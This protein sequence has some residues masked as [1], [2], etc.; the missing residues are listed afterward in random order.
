[1]IGALADAGVG[2]QY[3]SADIGS[4]P[5]R[6]RLIGEVRGTFDALNLLVN[7]A[8]IAPRV[9]AD[10]LDVTEDSFEELIR[11][12]LQGPC[13]LTQAVVGM[14]IEQ[15]EANLQ[16]AACVINVTSISAVVASVN[17]G[18]YCISKAGLSMASKLWDVRLAEYGIHT[19]VRSSTRHHSDRHDLW[20]A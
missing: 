1:V 18:V 3:F 4:Q 5:D 13:F 10:I 12:N 7:K 20:C 11:I 2:E 17:R 14:M 6:E 9:R 19:C 16:I 8:G 15:R